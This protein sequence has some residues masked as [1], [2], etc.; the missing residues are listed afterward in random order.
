M[1]KRIKSLI[2]KEFKD[3]FSGIDQCVIVSVRGI[4]GVSTNEMRRDLSG[5]DIRLGVLKNSLARRV[6]RD[7]NMEPL[8][9]YLTGPS[10]IVYGSDS[11]VDLVKALVEWDKKLEPFQI[12]GALLDGRGLD[13]KATQALAKLPNRRE[14]QGQVVL[15]ANSP[16]ARLSSAMGSPA[17]RI[18]GCVKTLI[19]QKESAA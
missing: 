19:E 11:I 12:K 14:L 16:G 3:R 9:E 7:L 4:D 2:E 6:F 15:L 1:S 5:K 17:S 18:A 13:A 10:A 8:N